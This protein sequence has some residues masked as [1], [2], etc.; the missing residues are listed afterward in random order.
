MMSKND[1]KK[2]VRLKKNS[3]FKPI[4]RFHLYLIREF[5]I[6]RT[7]M[8]E[9]QSLQDS[10]TDLIIKKALI[11]YVMI[12]MVSTFEY[13]FKSI[14]FH[15]GSDI[16]VELDRVLKSGYEENRGKALV[17]SFSHSNPKVVVEMYGKLLNRDL[18]Q[19][20]ETYFDNFNNEG[21]EHKIY[22]IRGIP[23]LSKNWD[24]FYRLFEYRNKMVHEHF[25]PLIKYS[26]LRN[27]IGSVFDMMAVAQSIG[28]NFDL[29]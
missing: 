28:W 21:I 17:D 5:K 26:E 13:F 14:A 22:H 9:I 10:G 2:K 11:E 23:L 19:D 12:R 18:I 6:L 8:V 16:S 4:G 3:E 20:A 24:N 7:I 15:I 1:K 25:S 27:M 29:H